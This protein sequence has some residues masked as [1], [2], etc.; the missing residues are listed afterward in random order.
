MDW[1]CNDVYES[2]IST[3]RL[4]VLRIHR[5]LEIFWMLDLSRGCRKLVKRI[6]ATPR[7]LL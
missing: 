2:C 4:Y 3:F 7:E 6:L 1:W 5:L